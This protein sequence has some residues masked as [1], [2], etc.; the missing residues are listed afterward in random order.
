VTTI[1]NLLKSTISILRKHPN[2]ALAFL[3]ELHLEHRSLTAEAILA[4]YKTGKIYFLATYTLLIIS[5]FIETNLI[6]TI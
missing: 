6:G 3:Y 1:Y 4:K 2:L 5:A